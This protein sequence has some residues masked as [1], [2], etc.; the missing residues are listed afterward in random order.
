MLKAVEMQEPGAD[1]RGALHPARLR[2]DLRRPRPMFR[3]RPA[4]SGGVAGR[5]RQDLRRE[6]PRERQR[7]GIAG[8]MAGEDELGDAGR[9]ATLADVV[10]E[11]RGRPLGNAAGQD[12][13]RRLRGPRQPGVVASGL[14][15]EMPEARRAR[16]AVAPPEVVQALALGVRL[17]MEDE[18]DLA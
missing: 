4:R 5:V 7:L 2:R 15:Q 1:A 13:S 18:T 8:P 17:V 10:P 14:P 16:R 12:G 3:V 6:A 11:A 9:S